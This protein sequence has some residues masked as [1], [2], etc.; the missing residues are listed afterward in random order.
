MRKSN[1][2]TVFGQLCQC[3][4]AVFDFSCTCWERDILLNKVAKFIRESQEQLENWETTIFCLCYTLPD[5]FCY[6]VLQDIPLPASAS[7]LGYCC[8]LCGMER[9]KLSATEL[10][11]KLHG[12]NLAVLVHTRAEALGQLLQPLHMQALQDLCNGCRW[13][14][15]THPCITNV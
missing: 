11:S 9:H 3:S 14:R 12:T 15:G 6:F 4:P 5:E 10:H 7:K 2:D 1:T 8:A 13:D